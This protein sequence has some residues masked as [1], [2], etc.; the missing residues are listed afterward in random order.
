LPAG[1]DARALAIVRRRDSEV[2][3]VGEAIEVG[4]ADFL[5]FDA[6]SI[7]EPL[8]GEVTVAPTVACVAVVCVFPAEHDWDVAEVEKAVADFARIEAV[9]DLA[10]ER[11]VALRR[12]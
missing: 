10:I 5:Y 6:E 7:L 3:Q 1:N 9:Q 11:Q 12:Y 2:N 4:E 8:C